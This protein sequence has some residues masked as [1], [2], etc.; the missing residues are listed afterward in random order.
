MVST[1]ELQYVDEEKFK[2]VRMDWGKNNIMALFYK[3]DIFVLLLLPAKE[4]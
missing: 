1:D 4:L 2:K 3:L